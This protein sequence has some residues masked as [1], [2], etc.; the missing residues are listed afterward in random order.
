[1]TCTVPLQKVLQ[2]S[3]HRQPIFTTSTK[4]KQL[5]ETEDVLRTMRRA[6]IFGKVIGGLKSKR[7]EKEREGCR[8]NG[9]SLGD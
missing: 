5:R 1:M 6:K 8:R 2:P 3:H 4:G 7:G 9:C